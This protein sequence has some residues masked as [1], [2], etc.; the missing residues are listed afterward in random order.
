MKNKFLIFVLTSIFL[1][2]FTF[3]NS[4][5]AKDN[6]KG[7]KVVEDNDNII[8]GNK[9]ALVIGNAKYK[10][11]SP[12]TNPP[13]DAEDIAKALKKLGFKVILK[14]NISNQEM[15]NSVEEFRK[16]LTS[17][18]GI[19]LFY[20][21]GH[22]M[23]VD[24][25]NYLIPVDADL[26]IKSDIKY[27]TLNLGLV[28]DNMKES[29]SIMNLVILDACRDNPFRGFRSTSSG[30]ANINA[31]TGSLI[32][33]ST[34]PGSVAEDGD[35]RNGTYTEKL[36]KYMNVKGLKVE[37]VFKK[38][39]QDVVEK[40][41]RKQTP[42]ENTSITGD[43]YFYPDDNPNPK[44]TPKPNIDIEVEPTPT[45]E[46]K[47]EPTPIPS[48]KPVSHTLKNLLYVE[49]GSFLMGNNKGK[50]NEKPSRKITLNSFYI[51]PLEITQREYES[52]I[53]DNPSNFSG[54]DLPIENVTWFDA[55]KFCNIKSKTDGLPLA[56]NEKTGELLD[57]DG[58]ITTDIT[59][60]KGYRL[61]TEAEWEY[62]SR[63]GKYN[64]PFEYSGSNKADEVAFYAKNSK[65]K[66]ANVKS[67]KPNKIGLYDMSGNV[68]EWCHDW[69]DPS[70]YL[71]FDK[72][73]NPIVS[74]KSLER[75]TRGG[76][77]LNTE[78][79]I[80]VFSRFGFEPDDKAFLLGFRIVLS[81]E[82]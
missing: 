69:Y 11:V 81:G 4:V 17:R 31:P 23:Q 74:Q 29:G 44:P 24:G 2:P 15:E 57:Q 50:N 5:I 13:N 33:Y 55:I 64:E 70:A 62:A 9:T 76:S 63:S 58:N 16:E 14:V 60:V 67:K 26:K 28:L 75:V 52:L 47:I 25:D 73:K 3:S 6:T 71:Y 65:Q 38:V 49:G 30:L 27:K 56:Y 80:T 72:T 59:K 19:G 41:G 43:F 51:S 45:P 21:S 78:K 53:G 18:K 46:P 7:Y 68:M 42:W 82:E 40:T 10:F 8:T 48:E 22:G 32:A 66:T 35:G 1:T 12:L 37:D 34:S 20:Y 77:I 54:L 39:R 36:L 79:D 61:P